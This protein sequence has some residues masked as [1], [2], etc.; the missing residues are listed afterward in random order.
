MKRPRGHYKPAKGKRDEYYNDKSE[1][2]DDEKDFEHVEVEDS[3]DLDDEPVVK[4]PARSNLEDDDDDAD[5]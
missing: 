1:A 5:L 2:D 3:E 4:K